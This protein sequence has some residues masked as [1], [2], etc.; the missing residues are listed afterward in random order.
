MQVQESSCV[1]KKKID[2][3]PSVKAEFQLTL[4]VGLVRSPQHYVSRPVLEKLI[5]EL[6]TQAG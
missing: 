3:T 6:R 5:A 2:G 1:K 4:P